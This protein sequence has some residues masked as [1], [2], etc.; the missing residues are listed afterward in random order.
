[1]IQIFGLKKCPD[2]RK[3]LRFFQER[4]VEAQFRDLALKPPSPGE[5]DDMAAALGGWTELLDLESAAAQERGL[6]YLDYDSREELLRDYRLYKT[7][8]VRAGRGRAA[9][10]AD[11]KA[12][13]GF[14]G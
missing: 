10:G 5:L 14:C 13:Q 8:L 1:M 9:L 2:T 7:P 6:A 3:A 11:E 12:W 4:R